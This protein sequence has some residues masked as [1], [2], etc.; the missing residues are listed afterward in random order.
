MLFHGPRPRSYGVVRSFIKPIVVFLNRLK[1]STYLHAWDSFVYLH[2]QMHCTNIQPYKYA[3]YCA[4][5]HVVVAIVQLTGIYG[6]KRKHPRARIIYRVI[7]PS[8]CT[9]TGY[10][11]R[12]HS[13]VCMFRPQCCVVIATAVYRGSLHCIA[14]LSTTGDSIP[15][16][17]L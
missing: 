17:V 9:T 12:S 1:P 13:Y 15:Y 4:A 2:V 7:N 10:I 6:C 5:I 11:P 14:A 16:S 3:T 8:N